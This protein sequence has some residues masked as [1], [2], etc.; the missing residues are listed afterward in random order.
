[1]TR[2]L[3]AESSLPPPPA[4]EWRLSPTP[5]ARAVDRLARDLSLPPALCRV[6][7]SRGLID[8]GEAKDFLRPRLEHLHPPGLMADAEKAAGRIL[9]AVEG[10]ETILVHGDYDV[11]GVASAALL[12]LWIRRLGGTVVPFVPHRLRDGYDLGDAGLEAAARARASL[13]VTC[14]SGIRAHEAVERARSRGVDVVITDHHTPGDSLP[15]AVAVVNPARSDCPYPDKGLCGAG[16][17]YK[18]CQ[19]LGEGRGIARDEL[20]PHLDLVALATVADLVP[21]RGENRVLVRFGLRYLARSTKP[22]L[23]ALLEVA[24]LEG[25]DDLDAGQVGFQ[26]AP[27]IN[28]GGR[29]GDADVPLRLLL[30]TDPRESEEL[31]R[32]LD[33]DNRRRREVD[34]ATLDDALD[35]LARDFDATSTF[36]VV[37]AAEGW[38]PG[39][40]GI[41]ASRVVERVHRPTVLISLNGDEGRGSARSIPGVHLF[42]ALQE[43]REHFRRFGGHRQAAGMDLPRDRIDAFRADFDRTVR[44]QLGGQPPRPVASGDA[45]LPL[46]EVTEELHRLLSYLGPFGIGNPRPV[47]WARGVRTA[48]RPRTVGTNHL[49]LRLRGEGGEVEAIGF[50][51]AD[52]VAPEGLAAGPLDALFQ[53][54]ENEYRGSVTLQARLLD[55]RPSTGA[56]A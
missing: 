11:D 29:M 12:T 46:G 39:V 2:P 14:D 10:G 9:K 49:K 36:G 47:F 26:V 31:A 22:G 34:R 52:R 4:P 43:C 21:L 3:G 28:A 27:R 50:G 54:R 45:S 44:A 51:M 24:G 13:L 33:E 55:L 48:G 32:E 5:D 1:V 37:L 20:L 35:R 6:L 53:L 18:L 41:V 42:D 7:A 16:V 38:H 19:L 40:I 56:P 15:P 30:S 8:P 17:I 25:R 23:R